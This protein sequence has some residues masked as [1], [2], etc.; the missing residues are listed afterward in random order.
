MPGSRS[1][2]GPS[3]TEPTTSAP[4]SM[5]AKDLV[6][7]DDDR[8][9]RRAAPG[10]RQLS[11]AAT[12]RRGLRQDGR[13]RRATGG[14]MQATNRARID[15][16]SAMGQTE[17][18]PRCLTRPTSPASDGPSEA[19][20]L[21][22]APWGPTFL[23]LPL[24]TWSGDPRASASVLDS[25]Q[26]AGARSATSIYK[27]EVGLTPVPDAAPAT[28]S[29]R[30]CRRLFPFHPS[31]QRGY[32]ELVDRGFPAA[33]AASSSRR[34]PTGHPRPGRTGRT[35]SLAPVPGRTGGRCFERNLHRTVP[36]PTGCT[37]SSR[38]SDRRRTAR[39]LGASDSSSRR[40]VPSRRTGWTPKFDHWWAFPVCAYDHTFA[41]N[42]LAVFDDVRDDPSIK[43]I[44]LTRS[45]PVEAT[46]ENVPVVV[47]L[48]SAEGQFYLLRVGPGLRQA[49][50]RWATSR[51]RC[52]ADPAQLHQRVARHSPEAVQPG[53]GRASASA[54][55]E[56]APSATT[57]RPG[58]S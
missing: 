52:G 49:Q 31:V 18:P 26:S 50:P 9:V 13:P 55:R 8:V 21:R 36:A 45:R 47:P 57:A 15:T 35:A 58:S 46:G 22:L 11:P 3:V 14:G 29:T 23:R 5:L 53:L 43:K 16:T 25:V 54:P 32:F 20:R 6:G 37:R 44:V 39:S 48:D 38:S 27:Y 24:A 1:M 17:E 12:A 2:P 4:Y 10:E 33:Q 56:G 7:W 34:T 19:A 41:G 28:R 40:R 51:G 30:S 42:E